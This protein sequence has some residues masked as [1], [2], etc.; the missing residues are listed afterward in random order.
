VLLREVVKKLP[1]PVIA[2]GG[3]SPENVQD[4]VKAGVYGIAVISA[5]CCQKDPKHAAIILK[6]RMGLK[7]G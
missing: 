1:I 4:V 5:V 7:N 3:I 2:I 6:N